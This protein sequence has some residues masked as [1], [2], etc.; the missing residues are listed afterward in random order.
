MGKIAIIGARG[1]QQRDEDV[2]IECFAWNKLSKIRNLRDY[3]TVLL[4]LLSIQD[5]EVINWAEFRKNLNYNSMRDIIVHE[6]SIIVVGDPRFS[7]RRKPPGKKKEFEEPFLAWTGIHF[8]WDNKPGDSLD[9]DYDYSYR[10]YWGYIDKL[11]SWDYS[12]R[13]CDHDSSIDLSNFHKKRQNLIVVDDFFCKNRYGGGLAFKISFKLVD[14]SRDQLLSWTGPLIFLPRINLNEEATIALILKDICGV[15]ISV[16]EPE[17][18]EEIKAPGQ[19]AIYDEIDRITLEIQSLDGKLNNAKERRENARS[20]LKL[21]YDGG[22]S[23]EEAVRNVLSELGAVVEAPEEPGK[24]DGWV[25]V[26]VGDKIFEGVLE[27]KHTRNDEFDA[28]GR[29]QLGEWIQRGIENRH[30]RYKGIFIGNNAIE[31]PINERPQGF[32]EE[33]KEAAKLQKIIA[34]HSV[35][36]YLIHS[37]RFNRK[38]NDEDMAEFWCCLFETEGVFD[39]SPYWEILKSGNE[40]D[41]QHETN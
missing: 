33:W 20:C 32:S 18:I 34:M 25:T 7:I 12:L 10:A 40:T 24:E 14:V 39:F 31:K 17:W 19:K 26:Q 22:P 28:K 35:D 9:F 2:C 41:E 37:L 27:V 29:R 36:L 8:E 23:L 11:K 5:K 38:L 4:N 1:F 13:N 30:K 3:D 21:L 15:E 16:P 6:G